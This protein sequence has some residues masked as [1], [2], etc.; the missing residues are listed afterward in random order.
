MPHDDPRGLFGT[1]YTYRGYRLEAT[2]QLGSGVR[3]TALGVGKVQGLGGS[4][5]LQND[6]AEVGPD[7]WF[8]LHGSSTIH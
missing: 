6:F 7:D 3:G 2:Q 4:F 8:K 1:V 5:N